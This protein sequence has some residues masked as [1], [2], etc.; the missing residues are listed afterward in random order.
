MRSSSKDSEAIT[1]ASRTLTAVGPNARL[2]GQDLEAA[3]RAL[4]TDLDGEISVSVPDLAQSLGELGLIDEYRLYYHPVMLGSG[5]SFFAGP[6]PRL[7]LMVIERI[8]EA[9]IRA[10]YLPA[11]RR[12]LELR[13]IVEQSRTSR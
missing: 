3:I 8:G 7:R 2:I 12:A 6:R 13:P 4:K 11:Q 5:K 1:S 10:I 9:V